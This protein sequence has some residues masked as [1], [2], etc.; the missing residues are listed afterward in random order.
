M[1]EKNITNCIVHKQVLW[2][3]GSENLKHILIRLN[4]SFSWGN[5][6]RRGAGLVLRSHQWFT[7]NN[8]CL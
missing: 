1:L 2:S 7:F 5:T 6:K 8:R 3:S 4:L